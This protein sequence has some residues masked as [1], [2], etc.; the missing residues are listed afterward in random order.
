MGAVVAAAQAKRSKGKSGA[1]FKAVDLGC[2]RKSFLTNVCGLVCRDNKYYLSN[3]DQDGSQQP[4]AA[5]ADAAFGPGGGPAGVSGR[6]G[7]G[8]GG[9]GAAA[10]RKGVDK[11]DGKGKAKGGGGNGAGVGSGKELL[12]PVPPTL[13]GTCRCVCCLCFYFDVGATYFTRC[14]VCG[15]PCVSRPSWGLWQ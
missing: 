6:G 15:T 14:R 2:N 1:G 3:P 12:Q 8:G 13:Y 4:S 9:G 5:A 11:K 10:A 7:G